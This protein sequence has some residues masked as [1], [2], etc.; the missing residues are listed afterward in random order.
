MNN[1]MSINNITPWRD[2]I[3]T[4]K[5][6]KSLDS[7]YNDFPILPY[8]VFKLPEN[9]SFDI[10]EMRDQINNIM[11]NTSTL[12]V[13]RD[14]DGRRYG[15]YKGLGFFS[16]KESKSPLEDHFIR[17]DTD[18][19]EVYSDNLYMNDRLPNLYEN[20]FTEKTSIYNDYFNTIFSKF[21][22]SISKA[23]ILELKNKGFL[24]S[25]VDFPYYKGIRLHA[26]ISGGENAYYEI[27]GEKFQIPAD[28]NWYFIDTGKYHSVWNE[29]PEDRITINVNLSG[30]LSDPETLAR[31]LEL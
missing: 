24:A 18:Q 4:V 21:R 13:K 31:N 25:H 12:S 15:R 22:S 17:R 20:D 28:G 5:Y 11:S 6:S 10:H 27:A 2:V 9:Y 16:R 1:K 30:I 26:T 7:W 3:D 14:N 19:G 23:S 8:N 29:G